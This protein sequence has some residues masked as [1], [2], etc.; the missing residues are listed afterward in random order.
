MNCDY[1]LQNRLEQTR[2]L[3]EELVDLFLLFQYY[4]VVR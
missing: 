2:F 3:F 1:F 4:Y